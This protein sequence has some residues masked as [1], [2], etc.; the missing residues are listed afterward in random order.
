M[1][2]HI[3]VSSV[4]L[5]RDRVEARSVL[6]VTLARGSSE[7]QSALDSNGFTQLLVNATRERETGRQSE[8]DQP[9]CGP[10]PDIYGK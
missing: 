7:T 4:F 8:N 6:S 2:I 3:Y 1:S 10:T 9:I 5:T